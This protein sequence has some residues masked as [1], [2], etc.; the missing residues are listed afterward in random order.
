MMD[1]LRSMA[2]AGSTI[3]FSSHILAEVER[4]AA[5][6]LVIRRFVRLTA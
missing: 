4:P 1:L 6:I 2:A 5:G 3:L